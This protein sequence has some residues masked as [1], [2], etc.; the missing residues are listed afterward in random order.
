MLSSALNNQVRFL[1][2]DLEAALT[3]LDIATTTSD[4]EI[5]QRNCPN[6]RH[7]YDTFCN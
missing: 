1:L 4:E 7:A 5:R 6:A 2:V 3:F